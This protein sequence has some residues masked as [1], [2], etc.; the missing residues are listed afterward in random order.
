MSSSQRFRGL[1]FQITHVYFPS[2]PPVS[3]WASPEYDEVAPITVR[4]RLLDIMHCPK[5]DGASVLSVLEQQWATIGC[6]RHD[7]VSGSGD[8]GGENEGAAGIHAALEE[9]SGSY[10]RRRCLGHWGW[11]NSD[12]AVNEEHQLVEETE[13]LETSE[14]HGLA[15]NRDRD[16]IDHEFPRR[17]SELG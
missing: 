4:R 11:R 12:A 15:D 10:V 13:D 8:G 17:A 14:R 2:F 3:S 16:G 5:K 7:F 1:R 9:I 6:N